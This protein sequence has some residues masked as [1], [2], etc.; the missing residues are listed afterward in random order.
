MD[1]DSNDIYQTEAREGIVLYANIDVSVR[2]TKCYSLMQCRLAS[3]PDKHA[4]PCK[5]TEQL[6]S[7]ENKCAI[8]DRNQ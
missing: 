8:N 3:Q 5:P 6:Q 1:I 4:K 2:K 7:P